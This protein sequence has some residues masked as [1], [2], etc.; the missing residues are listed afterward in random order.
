MAFFASR[1]ES[2][3]DQFNRYPVVRSAIAY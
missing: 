1:H 2:W 3:D